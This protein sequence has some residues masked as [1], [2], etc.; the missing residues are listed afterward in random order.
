[1]SRHRK[2]REVGF[3]FKSAIAICEVGFF[4]IA[5][6]GFGSICLP[7]HQSMANSSIP[8]TLTVAS[9]RELI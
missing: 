7:A 5:A 8:A 1:M 6:G 4:V 2:H 3:M 9:L